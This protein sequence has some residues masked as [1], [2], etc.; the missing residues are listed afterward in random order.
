MLTGFFGAFDAG[1]GASESRGRVKIEVKP[2][3]NYHLH[4]GE[5]FPVSSLGEPHS[6]YETTL[7]QHIP[8]PKPE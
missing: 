2:A 6:L 4:H 8:E 5:D 3:W 7:P 1:C